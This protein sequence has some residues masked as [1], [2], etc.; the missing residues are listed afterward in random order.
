MKDN[1]LFP[2]DPAFPYRQLTQ[3]LLNIGFLIGLAFFIC[4]TACGIPAGLFLL[5]CEIP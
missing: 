1:S 2:A 3:A 4:A 5:F